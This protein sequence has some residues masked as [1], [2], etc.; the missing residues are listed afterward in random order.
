MQKNF[1]QHSKTNKQKQRLKIKSPNY[2]YYYYYYCC[3]YYL[4]VYSNRTHGAPWWFGA[5]CSLQA[6]TR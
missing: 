5:K 6:E 4:S 1:T 2:Y 3:C